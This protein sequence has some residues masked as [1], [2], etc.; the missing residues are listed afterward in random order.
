MAQGIFNLKQVNQAIRQ[1]AWSAFNPPQFVEY[2]VVAGGGG[3]GAQ[4][5]GGGGAGGLLTGMVPVVAGT[6]YTVTVGGA[7]TGTA[8]NADPARGGNGTNSVFGIITTVGGGGGG[9][10]SST[11]AMPGGSGGGAGMRNVTLSRGVPGQGND[12]GVSKADAV[13]AASGGGGAGTR[14]MD[15]FYGG[16]AGATRP[17]DGGAGIASAISGTVITYAGGGGGGVYSGTGNL[18]PSQGGVGGGGNGGATGGGNIIA[19]P[20]ITNTGGGGGA[21]GSSESSVY[22]SGAN[23]GSGIV[24]VR[25][26]GTVQFY[27]GGTVNYANGYIVHTFYANGTLAPTTPTQ[28]SNTYQISRSLRFN[29]A[30]S[31]TLTRTVSTTNR[32]TWTFSGWIKKGSEGGFQYIL[33]A[34]ASLDS[35]TA[36]RFQSDSFMLASATSNNYDGYTYSAAVHRDASAWYHIVAVSDT[37]NVV[38]DDRFR[39]YVNGVRL[40][41]SLYSTPALN[42]QTYINASSFTQRIGGSVFNGTPGSFFNGQMTELNFIDGQALTASSFGEYDINTGVWIPRAYGGSYGTNGFYLKFSDNTNTTAATLGADYSGNGN[43]WTPNNFSVSAGVGNDSL[44]DSPTPYGTDTGV[45]G[46]VRGNYCTWNP[47]SFVQYD[48][49]FNYKTTLTNGNLTASFLT[50]FGWALGT[51]AVP[52]NSKTY[53]E[54]TIDSYTQSNG[55]IGF[56]GDAS[57]NFGSAVNGSVYIGDGSYS[58][59]DSP[60]FATGNIIGF[61][62]DRVANAI[63]M[64]KNGSLVYTL[65][66]LATY[67]LTSSSVMFP[68]VWIRQAGDQITGNF[69][70]RPFVYSAPAGYK[71]LCTTNLPTPTIGATATTQANKYFNPVTYT[72]AGGTQAV[73]VGFQPDFVWM[74]RRSDVGGHILQ[75]V[76]SGVTKGLQ[77]EVTSSE[78]TDATTLTEFN[79]AGF[80]VGGNSQTNAS[81]STYVAWNWKAG[82]T[83]VTNTQGSITST[84]STSPTTG[85][86][87]VTYT[88]NGTAGATVG[89]GLGVA[90][91]L[92]IWKK[93]SA[94]SNWF[95]WSKSMD[96]ANSAT[97]WL[98]L[99]SNILR[100]T[101]AT[102]NEYPTYKVDPTSTL[103]TLNGTGSSN[104]TNDSSA[105]YVA[106]SFAPVAGYSAL[107]YYTGNGNVDGPF[108]YLGFRPAFLLIKGIHTCYWVI[109]DVARN[110]YNI[111]NLQLWPNGT[112]AENGTIG[113]LDAFSNGFKLRNVGAGYNDNNVTYIYMAIAEHPFKYSLSR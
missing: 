79:S 85:F 8:Y 93:R 38:G 91:N 19:T 22:A 48:G 40:T 89:H 54:Y 108:V 100:Q 55:W 65:T 110:T 20:G 59:N 101:S 37:T 84:V 68:A 34:D 92:V 104:G 13:Y 70:Q 39:I 47:L 11:L 56:I 107:G 103:I 111:M 18:F 74:K 69:G 15:A 58:V 29:S 35:W 4:S 102:T 5:S 67:G 60:G 14:G 64:Y 10:D 24:I 42:Y 7:G 52:A 26:P 81:G 31:T 106:Y 109:F 33:S 82:G 73:N 49:G 3:G 77:T 17:G 99:N 96:V 2:L 76:L 6:S 94:T 57:I 90:P 28:Y 53:I 27:T 63:Y 9:S 112:D 23:G 16:T 43:N 80:K 12:G 71:A 36:V 78:F 41:P 32:R 83:G 30:D 87:I 95:V 44:V 86:S 97:G 1:G 45:G 61:A 25:Y 88:G 66:G 51:Q 21:G 50:N 98:Y 62:F 105:T 75:N 46:E 72:G 113:V